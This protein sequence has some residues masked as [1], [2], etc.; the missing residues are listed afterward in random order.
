[1][2]KIIALFM[3]AALMLSFTACGGSGTTENSG[4]NAPAENKKQPV[5]SELYDSNGTILA[6]ITYEY[7]AEG[8]KISNTTSWNYGF[9]EGSETDTYTYNENGDVLTE[10]KTYSYSD[11]PGV[12]KYTYEDGRLVKETFGDDDS[13]GMKYVYGAD[14]RIAESYNFNGDSET[15]R[16]TYSY[17]DNTMV[18]TEVWDD[19]TFVYTTTYN[20]NGDIAKWE[21]KCNDEIM[22]THNY[23]YDSDGNLTKQDVSIESWKMEGY[24]I[25]YYE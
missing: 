21:Y 6:D 12:K 22:I 23:S 18:Q 7:D 17:T 9:S 20:S 14:G 3:S 5:R 15:L 24:V 1:M 13:Y 25:H 11:Y 19:W 4:G 8:R 2:K 10:T 16:Q